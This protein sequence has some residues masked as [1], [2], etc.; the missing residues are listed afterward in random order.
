MAPL[1]AEHNG[2]W[3]GVFRLNIANP[4]EAGA[5]VAATE[6]GAQV[7]REHH[8]FVSGLELN[9]LGFVHVD[10]GAWIGQTGE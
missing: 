9:P 4:Y 10:I 2:I 6:S 7:S 5:F 8:R 1:N 3:V